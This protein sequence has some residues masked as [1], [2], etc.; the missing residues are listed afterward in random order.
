[1]HWTKFLRQISN[2]LWCSGVWSGCWFVFNQRILRTA[3]KL[4]TSPYILAINQFYNFIW[5]VSKFQYN[6]HFYTAKKRLVYDFMR[7]FLFTYR[8][9]TRFSHIPVCIPEF[10]VLV[11]LVTFTYHMYTRTAIYQ[12]HTRIYHIYQLYTNLWKPLFCFLP[13]SDIFVENLVIFLGYLCIFKYCRQ[14]QIQQA[15]NVCK[16]QDRRNSRSYVMHCLKQ[17]GHRIV[18]KYHAHF[19]KFFEWSLDKPTIC[20]P[21]GNK[22]DA[23]SVMHTL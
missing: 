8:S 21:I 16:N 11:I 23:K 19:I 9:Y 2:I 18:Q 4:L 5:K 1:M 14:T 10:S 20:W 17:V 22:T 3:S 12:L 13:W 7:L 15:G 6:C